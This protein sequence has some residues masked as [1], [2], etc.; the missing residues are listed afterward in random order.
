MLSCI[1]PFPQYNTLIPL[2]IIILESEMYK[3]GMSK[4][5]RPPTTSIS[6]AAN[7]LNNDKYL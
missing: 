7:D 6:T 2:D 4:L 3:Q 5:S 1:H